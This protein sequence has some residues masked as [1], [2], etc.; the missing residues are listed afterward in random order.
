[1]STDLNLLD[2]LLAQEGEGE[3]AAP[4]SDMW[5]FFFFFFR[6]TPVANESSQAKGQIRAAATGLHCSHSNARSLTH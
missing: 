4:H 2:P 5:V 6:A 1:M 3:A